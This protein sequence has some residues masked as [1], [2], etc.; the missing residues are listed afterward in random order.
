M[1]AGFEYLR[2][3][4]GRKFTSLLVLALLVVHL[5]GFY[6][7]FI[8]RLG[9]VRMEMRQKLAG[10]LDEELDVVKIPRAAF[11]SIWQDE[12][13]MNWNGKMYDIARM[14]S[15]ADYIMVYCLHDEDED[16]LLNFLSAVVE[17]SQ[18]DTK[19]TPGSV[20]QFLSLEYLA[21]S[22]LLPDPD[23]SGHLFSLTGYCRSLISFAPDPLSPPPRA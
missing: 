6:V 19:K 8:V 15:T 22:T 21:S 4:M 7:Y 20:I 17:T 13:E 10:L 2:A 5:A 1:P 18:Q 9:E 23:E 14:E 16:G 11:Q 3:Y 12:L